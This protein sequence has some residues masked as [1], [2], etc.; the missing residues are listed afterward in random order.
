M[1]ISRIRLLK[2]ALYLII[3]ASLLV[4]NGCVRS[5][6]VEIQQGNVIS[7]EQIEKITPGTS[8]NE[9]RFILGTPLIEDPFHA[10]RWDYF[11]SLDPAKG[12]LVTKY[13]LSVWFENDQVLRTVVEG[14]GLPG[15]IEPDLEEDSPGF[16]S[17]LWD[18]VTPSDD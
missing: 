2:A 5:Y 3:G 6:R 15:A 10:E 7:A 12:E 17:Q 11:Y 8:R 1:S 4:L 13:R 14:A 16:F 9:V 18:K